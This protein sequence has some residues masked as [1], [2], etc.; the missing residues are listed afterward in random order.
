M[1]TKICSKCKIEKSISEFKKAKGYKDG[2]STW[3]IECKKEYCRN[4]GRK[5]HWLHR[6]KRLEYKR[7]WDNKN[8]EYLLEYHDKYR[9]KHKEEIKK[10][11][12]IYSSIRYHT[13]YMK[14]YRK[15][16][17]N[18]IKSQLR[19][20]VWYVLKGNPKLSTT[21]KLL[22]CSI[23]KLKQYLENQFRKGMTWKNYGKWHI[24]HIIPCASF[25]FSK[26]KEQKKCFNYK[27]LQPLWAIENLKKKDKIL[28]E[29]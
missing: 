4:Y 14:E 25:D 6:K 13:K 29:S 5:Y 3:C 17:N 12:K 28:I 26:L 20:R 15:N 1:K 23:E 10:Q 9:Q 19:N 7:K 21:M 2:I 18:R 22:G 24:D 11:R 8:K 27:N 16:I